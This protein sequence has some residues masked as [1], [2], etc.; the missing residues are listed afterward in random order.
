MDTAHARTRRWIVATIAGVAAL[1]LSQV[2][3]A[4]AQATG[5]GDACRHE[6]RQSAPFADVST[7]GTHAEAVACLWVYN[8][9]RG[10]TATGA[11]GFAYQPG[12]VVN[13]QQMASFV[14]QALDVV[15]DRHHAL[16][17]ADAGD[18][19]ERFSDGD[20]ISQ[21]HAVNVVRLHDAGV[22]DG[23]P[24][25]TYRPGTAINRAQMASFLVR[26]IEDVTGEELPRTATFDDVD[27]N[28]VHAASIEKLASIGVTSGYDGE[29]YAPAGDTTRAQ[30]ASFVA[31]TLD[32][33]AGEGYLVPAEYA[34]HS[35]G[36]RIFVADVDA[37]QHA[38][39]DRA[40]F[41]VEGSG[42][43]GWNARYVD[44]AI[45]QGSGH[46]VEV[47]GDAILAVTVTGATYPDDADDIFSDDVTVAGDGIVEVVSGS[48]FE[49][50]Q[51]IWVG[52]TGVHHFEIE[53]TT[54]GDFYL[55]VDHS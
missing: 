1:T 41:R 4:G 29:Q 13:R 34:A 46:Q 47:E 28:S 15:L 17:D 54:D 44:E 31:R 14:A 48:V 22:V 37:G 5:I 55:D 50:H 38:G 53:R 6:A 8:I 49:G 18:A 24:D 9:V 23:Y 39:Y 36:A 40:A 30:M 16:P 43:A 19:A 45:A 32:Y 35:D 20:R 21:A 11:D 42:D 3:P 26:A 10:T 33:L 25:D 2:G 7:D 52:T 27:E 12:E 51:Q